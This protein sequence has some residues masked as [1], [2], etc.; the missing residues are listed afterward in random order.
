MTRKMDSPGT[1]IRDRVANVL[2]V[3]GYLGVVALAATAALTLAQAFGRVLLGD[4]PIA[5]GT[6]AFD[7]IYIYVRIS[8]HVFDSLSPRQFSDLDPTIQGAL[9]IV[10]NVAVILS[11]CWSLIRLAKW[12]LNR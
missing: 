9:I 11:G 4:F 12:L 6:W 1:R 2:A 10:P 7:V 8:H 5:D 3:L